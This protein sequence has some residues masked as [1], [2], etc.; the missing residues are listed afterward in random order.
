MDT[1]EPPHTGSEH[2]LG[3]PDR[4]V[5]QEI[6]EE[7]RE[8]GFEHVRVVRGASR[9]QER[10]ED[11]RDVEW[12]VHVLDTRLPDAPGGGAYEGLRDR[13]TDLAREH[14]GWY[15]EPGDDRPATG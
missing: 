7:L 1:T 6:A 14:D 3:L 2:L 8:E 12:A 10:G 5:A 11:G 15:D 13:F 9:S 4:D